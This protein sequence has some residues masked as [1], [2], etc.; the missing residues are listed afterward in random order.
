MKYMWTG[1]GLSWDS[2]WSLPCLRTQSHA[3]CCWR[4]NHS[5]GRSA[6]E[7]FTANFPINHFKSYVSCA[8]FNHLFGFVSPITDDWFSDDELL[9]IVFEGLDKCRTSPQDFPY[10]LLPCH[11]VSSQEV[12]VVVA[13]TS[14]WFASPQFQSRFQ[15]PKEMWA[16]TT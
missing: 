15:L 3:H 4:K 9:C 6:I 12:L 8:R 5:G 14:L 16:R 1:T 13:Q 2:G 7:T 10:D 11:P